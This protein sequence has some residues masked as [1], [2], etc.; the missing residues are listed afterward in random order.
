VFADRDGGAEAGL[1]SLLPG[2]PKELVRYVADPAGVSEASLTTRRGSK[3]WDAM[4]VVVL[5][6]ALLEPW[7]ANVISARHYGQPKD[8]ADAKF[9]PPARLNTRPQEVTAS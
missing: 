8:I 9:G 6:L 1:R 5:L 4:L 7:L 3:L 2:T